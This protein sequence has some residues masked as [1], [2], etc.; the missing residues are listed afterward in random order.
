MAL[1]YPD[2]CLRGRTDCQP[3]AQRESDETDEDGAPRSFICVGRLPKAARMLD[4]DCYRLCWKNDDV[5]EMGDWDAR[6]LIDTA[7]VITQ[8]LSMEANRAAN[9]PG[10]NPG[11]LF[12]EPSPDDLV[13]PGVD[14]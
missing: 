14:P 6:D 2:V 8:A 1:Y 4:Q 12:P 11:H 3:L 13:N 9:Y 7:A 10:Q 5:D